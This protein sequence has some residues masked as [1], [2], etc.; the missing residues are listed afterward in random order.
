M[1]FKSVF[2]AFTLILFALVPVSWAN[3]SGVNITNQSAT[4]SEVSTAW[5]YRIADYGFYVTLPDSGWVSKSSPIHGVAGFLKKGFAMRTDIFVVPCKTETEFLAFCERVKHEMESASTVT[6]AHHENGR[7]Q[8][9]HL[10]QF[11]LGKEKPKK[12]PSGIYIFQSLVWIEDK[13]IAVRACFQGESLNVS[14]SIH[15]AS[16]KE[17]EK[18]AR[19]ICLSIK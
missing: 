9:G 4:A 8:S 10:Y 17:L 18:S 19:F 15:G 7:T 6:D 1:N 12:A 2:I 11:S 5:D 16:P 3:E 13:K 14:A